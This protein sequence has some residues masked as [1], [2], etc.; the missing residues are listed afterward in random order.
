MSQQHDLE[1]PESEHGTHSSQIWKPKPSREPDC[2]N[3][4]KGFCCAGC[5][6]KF[7]LRFQ[8]L[9]AELREM[10]YLCS[11]QSLPDISVPLPKGSEGD[12]PRTPVL[13]AVCYVN[14][15]VLSE[16]LPAILAS[17]GNAVVVHG[18][19]GMK[20]LDTFLARVP[21]KRA[22]QSVQ[23][24]HL[25]WEYGFTLGVSPTTLD[26]PFA[27]QGLRTLSIDVEAQE[28]IDM[29]GPFHLDDDEVILAAFKAHEITYSLKTTSDLM[30]QFNLRQVFELPMLRS[31]TFR[32]YGGTD[33][34]QELGCEPVEIFA[35][36]V[37]LASAEANKKSADFEL[38]FIFD[39]EAP[40]ADT[41]WG[42]CRWG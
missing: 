12:C 9:P 27:C 42:S 23:E 16:S 17:C 21:N 15:L 39:F 26:L 10:V 22:A 41:M 2:Q 40:H 28:C 18:D 8:M 24:L 6:Q 34:A 35:S 31:L 33:P 7:W 30:L 36:L 5:A 29:D 11:F 19:A 13:P 38:L 37:S 3:A 25:K 20:V 1:A 32:C 4:S 14:R